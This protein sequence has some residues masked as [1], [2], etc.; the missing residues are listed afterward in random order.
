MCRKRKLR[1]GQQKN[2]IRQN[3]HFIQEMY[4]AGH[5]ALWPYARFVRKYGTDPNGKTKI[6]GSRTAYRTSG[7]CRDRRF[8]DAFRVCK[9]SVKIVVL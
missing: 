4:G 3:G 5:M 6:R 2:R 1:Q 7:K 8:S 9:E